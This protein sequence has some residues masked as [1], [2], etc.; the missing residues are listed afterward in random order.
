MIGRRPVI[1]RDNSMINIFSL[2]MA[3]VLSVFAFI[4]VSRILQLG[5]C[6]VAQAFFRKIDGKY[7]ANHVIETKYT[8]TE[9][10]CSM[11]CLRLESC[12]SVNYKTSGIGKGRCELNSKTLENAPHDDGSKSSPEFNHLY[13][14][15]KVRRQI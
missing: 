9:L 15:E 6:L 8:E 2:E 14:I 12:A 11:H 13:V 5:E 7:L 1:Q 3:V 4:F 10:E